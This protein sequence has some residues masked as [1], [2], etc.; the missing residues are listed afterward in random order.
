[1]HGVLRSSP[2]RQGRPTGPIGH[3]PPRLR[4]SACVNLQRA[5]LDMGCIARF[6][7]RLARPPILRQSAPPAGN[8]ERPMKTVTLPSGEAVPA[9]GQGTWQM[10]GDRGRRAEEIATLRLALDLGLPLIDTA[11]LYQHV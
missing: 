6:R 7:V 1:G 11:V 4:G 8:P 9:L 10:A 2:M 5:P 3:S